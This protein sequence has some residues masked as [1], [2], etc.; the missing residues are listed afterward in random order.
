M[1]A[2]RVRASGS[3]SIDDLAAGRALDQGEQ[4]DQGALAGAGV[5][6]DKHH[7]AAF[8]LEARGR[9]SASPPLA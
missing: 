9:C 1:R 8:D 3:P 6:G 2:P 4:L 7:L 5:A